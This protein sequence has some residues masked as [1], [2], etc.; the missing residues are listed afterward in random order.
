MAKLGSYFG[1]CPLVDQHNL[2]GI[3]EASENGHIIVALC[4]NIVAKY[5]VSDQKQIQSWRTK[6]K[7]SSPVIFNKTDKK[8]V[9]TFNS[10]NIKIWSDDDEHLDKLKKYKFNEPIHTLLSIGEESFIIFK[11]GNIFPLTQCINERKQLKFE[12][13]FKEN[14]EIV[15]VLQIQRENEVFFGLIVNNDNKKI[16]YLM[17]I[18]NGVQHLLKQIELKRDNVEL[19]G[20]TLCRLHDKSINFLSFW[21]DNKL[22]SLQINNNKKESCN[23]S[24][25]FATIESI[26]SSHF[27]ALT[28]ISNDNIAIYGADR[29]QEGAKLI[30]YNTQY[31]VGQSMLSFKLFSK[32]KKIW[33]IENYLFMCSG[34]HLAVVPFFINTEHLS[35]LVGSHK[36]D[37]TDTDLQQSVII[38]NLENEKEVQVNYKIPKR[39]KK[40]V[41]ELFVQGLS[42]VDISNHLIPLYMENDEIE[43]LK[44]CLGYFKDLSEKCLVTLLIYFIQKELKEKNEFN[45]SPN[46]KLIDIILSTPISEVLI[47]PYLKREFDIA[48]TLY[49]IQYISHLLSQDGHNLPKL[50]EME[51]EKRL[52]EWGSM[53]LDANYQKFLLTEDPNVKIVL[54]DFNEI[55]KDYSENLKTIRSV[56]PLCENIV[57]KRIPSC[58]NQPNLMYCIKE[59]KLS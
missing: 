23:L 29:N 40:K 7:L 55:V 45:N 22:Y 28:P 57:K 18:S 56:V 53:L 11:N 5:R 13:I 51:T 9:G 39:I 43:C 17:V 48:T 59:I 54:S 12:K 38:T 31:K 16:L 24:D 14:E 25:I 2:L 26:S 27:A 21:S 37:L 20:Y 50:D 41:K 4:K 36:I 3:S 47:M 30:I 1:L 58:I 32:A 35:A 10:V 49:L 6:D 19:S 34:Q 15:D 52:I 8:Y 46:F 44:E 42:E 33:C